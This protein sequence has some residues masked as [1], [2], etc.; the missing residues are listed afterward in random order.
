MNLNEIASTIYSQSGEKF[1][2]SIDTVYTNFIII[3]FQQKT[4]NSFKNIILFS[5]PQVSS[6]SEVPRIFYVDV[7]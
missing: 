5:S 3:F 6:I 2:A 4:L 7:L 1:Q